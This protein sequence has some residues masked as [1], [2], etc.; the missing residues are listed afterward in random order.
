MAYWVIEIDHPLFLQQLSTEVQTKQ[1]K[2]NKPMSEIG[3]HFNTN[4]H[5]GLEDV[6][7]HILD[8]IHAYPEGRKARYLRNLIEY[9][10]IQRLHTNAPTGLNIM[11]PWRPWFRS[12]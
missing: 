2:T 8:F 5:R 11:D 1:W 12:G 3:R 7:I 4:G 6:E 10:W 9:N